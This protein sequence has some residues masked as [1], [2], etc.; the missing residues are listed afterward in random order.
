MHLRRFGKAALRRGLRGQ[1]RKIK[2][3]VY[4]NAL[5]KS[6]KDGAQ[7]GRIIVVPNEQSFP[8]TVGGWFIGTDALHAVLFHSGQYIPYIGQKG[9]QK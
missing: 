2:D 4:G 7:S 9:T 3:K 5:G 8:H 1:T 6:K